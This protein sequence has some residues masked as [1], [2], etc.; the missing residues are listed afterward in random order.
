MAFELGHIVGCGP[1]EN[2]FGL[3][4]GYENPGQP[5]GFARALQV[6]GEAKRASTTKWTAF[7][8]FI[9]S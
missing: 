7:R 4:Q 8:A 6:L 9:C 3:R 1:S 2:P 5:N